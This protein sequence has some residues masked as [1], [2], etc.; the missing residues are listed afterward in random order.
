MLTW[1][2]LSI[3]GFCISG[4]N[5]PKEKSFHAKALECGIQ[6]DLICAPSV[7]GLSIVKNAPSLEKL[8]FHFDAEEVSLDFLTELDFVEELEIGPNLRTYKSAYS[9]N[10]RFFEGLF[11]R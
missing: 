7:L 8:S 3:L 4:T 10:V 2:L 6:P 9:G 5:I 1:F 11:N